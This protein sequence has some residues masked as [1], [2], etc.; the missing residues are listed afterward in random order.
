MDDLE[1]LLRDLLREPVVQGLIIAV[2]LAVIVMIWIT[3]T[4]DDSYTTA[5]CI[6]QWRD[7]G[8]YARAEELCK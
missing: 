7:V 2:V 3:A 5:D 4:A 8:V 1:K 6:R